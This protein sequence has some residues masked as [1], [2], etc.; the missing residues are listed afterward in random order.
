MF[1]L[2]GLPI[3]IYIYIMN[4]IFFKLDTLIL[5][6]TVESVYILSRIFLFTL[7]LCGL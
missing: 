5:F 4:I 6:T 2:P 1:A 7:A 3:V